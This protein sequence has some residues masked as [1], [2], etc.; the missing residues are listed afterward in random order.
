MSRRF[1]SRRARLLNIAWTAW[2]RASV[3]TECLFADP[4]GDLAVLGPPDNQELSEECEMYE[5]L[6]ADVEGFP[7]TDPPKRG[8]GWVLSLGG[9][10]IECMVNHNGGPL[11]IS[12]NGGIEGGMSGSPILAA[13]GSAIGV[14]S[15]GSNMP[16]S[17]PNAR[18]T[19]N[20]PGWLLK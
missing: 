13:D 18:L 17:G 3:W 11:W 2:D 12:P 15:T 7:I 8:F 10:W 20:L 5:A 9:Q 1:R 19:Y 14:I 16:P 6:T 4:I